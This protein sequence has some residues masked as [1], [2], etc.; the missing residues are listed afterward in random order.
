MD[1]SRTIGRRKRI[2]LVAH[3]NRKKDLLNWIGKNRDILVKHEICGTGTT[4][5]LISERQGL[6]VYPYKSGPLGGDLQIGSRISEGKIDLLIFFWD[7]L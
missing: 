6:E 3:D 2:A 5:S 1:F 7:P 4:A